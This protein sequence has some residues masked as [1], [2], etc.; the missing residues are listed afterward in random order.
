M[1]LQVVLD[2]LAKIELKN[3]SMVDAGSITTAGLPSVISAINEGLGRLYSRFPFREK[4]LLIE[5]ISNITEYKMLAKYAW[6]KRN[7]G[8]ELH[9]FIMDSAAEPYTGDLIKILSVWNSNGEQLLLNDITNKGS[10]FT[11]HP[12][13]LLVQR[14]L[15]GDV[16]SLTYQAMADEILVST[17]T[18]T[19]LDVPRSLLSALTSYVAYLIFESIGTQEA[20]ARSQML[21][22]RFEAICNEVSFNDLLN[23]SVTSTG[24]K[25]HERGFV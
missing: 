15:G 3:L 21:M 12:D 18:D 14:P 19:E 2:R 9:Y 1:Q 25:F 20:V 22:G 6:S 4:T 23:I 8:N 17:P 13:T 11:P 5:L 7:T 16:L 24:T 10:L